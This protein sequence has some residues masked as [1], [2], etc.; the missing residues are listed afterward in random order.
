M[1]NLNIR[2]IQEQVLDF[3]TV[4]LEYSLGEQQ[5]YLWWVTRRK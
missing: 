5:S 2:D 1:A 3:D 4:L